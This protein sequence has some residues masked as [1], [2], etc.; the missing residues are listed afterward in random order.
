MVLLAACGPTI[1]P[2]PTSPPTPTPRAETPRPSEGAFVPGAYPPSDDAPCDQAKPPDATHAAY[3]GELKRIV[4]KDASTVLFEL[5]SP[6][7][8]FLTKLASPAFGINDAGWLRSHVSA[9]GS[10]DQPIVSQLNGTGPY[11]LGAWDRDTQVSLDRNSA[12]WGPAP[13]NERLIV[14]WGGD[15]TTRVSEL[16]NGTVDGIDGIDPAGV[17]TVAGDVT[18]QALP[19]AGRDVVYLGFSTASP[20]LGSEKVRQAIAGGLDR[21]GI[22]RNDFPPGAE[23]ATH[24]T[25]CEVPHGCAG[26]DW[27]D[28]DPVQARELLAAT[29]LSAGFTTTLYYSATPTPSMPDPGR[30][31]AEIQTELLANLGIAARLVVM[32]DAAFHRQVDDGTLDGLHLLDRSGAYPDASAYLDPVFGGDAGPEFGTPFPDI[33]KALASGR[34]TVD[35]EKR[36]TAYAKANDLIRQ[37]VPMIPIGRATQP[38]AYLADVDGAQSSPVG[39]EHF[40]AMTPGDRRQLV[41]L[42]TSQPPGLYC[43]DETDP[44]AALVCAQV[45]DG[46]YAFTPGGATPIPAL[47]TSCDPNAALTVWTCHLRRNVL[48]DDGS[49]LDAND[50]VLSFAVQ[51]DAEHPLHRGRT[52][53]FATFAAWF[54]GFLHPPAPPLPPSPPASASPSGSPGTSAPPSGRPPSP[55]AKPSG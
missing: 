53:D 15:S 45:M 47:A 33:A 36:E 19:R 5:C 11:R 46:L 37:H 41:W 40:A 35:P 31:A 43:A 52:G 34:A 2:I 54:G 48:F 21:A 25:P 26:G 13:K 28:Y 38:T 17:A 29:G 44:I 16:Q 3:R 39:L 12:Y 50:V 20:P 32:P 14:R 10:G 23:V 4:A 6:D 22:V 8:A 9:G 51:W 42:T 1:P 49:R 24:Y 7:V 55:T 27:T 30:V 18:L